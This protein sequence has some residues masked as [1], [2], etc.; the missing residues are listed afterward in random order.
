M[1]DK[2]LKV[3][4]GFG[5]GQALSV[6]LVEDQLADLRKA[7]ESGSGWFDLP[8][9]EGTVALNLASVVFIRVDD[10]SHSIGF[11]G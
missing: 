11:A 3:E 6:K 2:Q 4:I 9:Q 10:A 5:I 7:V 8:T 1:A